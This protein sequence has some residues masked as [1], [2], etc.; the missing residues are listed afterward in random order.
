MVASGPLLTPPT[1]DASTRHLTSPFPH[2]PPL[3][4]PTISPTRAPS[5]SVIPGLSY[6]RGLAYIQRMVYS[7]SRDDGAYYVPFPFRFRF[8]GIEYPGVFIGSNT[9]VPPL[10]RSGVTLPADL[11][12]KMHPLRQ[13]RLVSHCG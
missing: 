13:Q 12:I 8:L 5:M 6:P 9:W 2:V 11:A 10:R 7:G 4:A 1:S 3:Q